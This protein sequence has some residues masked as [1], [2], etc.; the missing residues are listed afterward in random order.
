MFDKLDTT[1]RFI[2]LN[3]TRAMFLHSS[4]TAFGLEAGNSITTGGA[5][6]LV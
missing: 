4:L 2:T 6:V 5:N 1:N 3:N